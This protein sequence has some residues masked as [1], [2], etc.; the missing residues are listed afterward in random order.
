MHQREFVSRRDLRLLNDADEALM[1]AIAIKGDES[2]WPNTHALV[3][4]L[5]RYRDLMHK[6][7]VV[8]RERGMGSGFGAEGRYRI[9]AN[10]IERMLSE[11]GHD[12]LVI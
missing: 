7:G 3:D 12:H 5:E 2:T 11:A 4:S 9:T 1:E 6:V 10:I 8:V